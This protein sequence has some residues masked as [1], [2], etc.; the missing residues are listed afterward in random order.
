MSYTVKVNIEPVF[1]SIFAHDC[2]QKKTVAIPIS[3][4]KCLLVVNSSSK[5]GF[6]PHVVSFWSNVK[7]RGW[8]FIQKAK[9]PLGKIPKLNMKKVSF[10][11]VG[12]TL[13][14]HC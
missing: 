9:E 3:H 7:Q 11:S 6:S 12:H 4:F 2:L 8:D 10:T 5:D 13:T 14:Y 1:N